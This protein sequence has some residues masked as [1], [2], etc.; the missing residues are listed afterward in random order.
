MLNASY[1]LLYSLLYP[2]V[3]T[4]ALWANLRQ[5]MCAPS[6]KSQATWYDAT[7]LQLQQSWLMD[8]LQVQCLYFCYKC[9]CFIFAY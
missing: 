3:R 2:P 8:F 9:F 1:A 4:A 7:N 5:D 6:T